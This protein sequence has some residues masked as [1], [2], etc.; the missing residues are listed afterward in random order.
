MSSLHTVETITVDTICNCIMTIIPNSSIAQMEQDTLEAE[1]DKAFDECALN[2][3]VGGECKK[4][5][6]MP[7]QIR[8][9]T[10]KPVKTKDDLKKALYKSV[11]A[12]CNQT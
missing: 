3:I 5:I 7:I 8:L 4:Y 2:I 1:V 12:L 11:D 6:D 10:S 9:K